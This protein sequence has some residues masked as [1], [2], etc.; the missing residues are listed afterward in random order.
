MLNLSI[1]EKFVLCVLDS[2]KKEKASF[3]GGKYPACIIASIFME[4]LLNQII[5]L[6]NKKNIVINKELNMDKEYFKLVYDK[7]SSQKPRN[8]KKWIEYYVAGFTNKPVKEVVKSAIG[9]LELNNSLQLEK[10]KGFF[11][12]NVIYNVDKQSLESVIQ[13]VRA[14][15]LQ[16]DA[17]TKETTILVA[18]MLQCDLLKK[19]FSKHEEN[20]VKERIKEVKKSEEWS[21]INSVKEV[22]DELDMMMIIAAIV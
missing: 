2:E 12:E 13:N 8:L 16:N 20:K 11:K 10:K 22:L 7:I 3:Y 21:D 18:I 5:T 9:A 17:L 15:F 19:Y 14:E 1:V 4:L 6:D